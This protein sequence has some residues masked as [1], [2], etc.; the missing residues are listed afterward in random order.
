MSEENNLIFSRCPGCGDELEVVEGPTDRYGGSSAAC[1]KRFTEILVREYSSPA[2]FKVH[3]LTVDAYMA[4]HPSQSSPAAIQSVWVHLVAIY[5]AL[6]QQKPLPFIQKVMKKLARPDIKFV[7]LV[8]PPGPAA[9]TVG[10][11]WEAASAEEHQQR[12]RLWAGAVWESWG[13]RQ[14]RIRDLA[15]YTIAKMP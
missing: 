14:E 6:E 10:H 2:H 13:D 1:W 7:A 9:L 5:L 8:P 11:V 15:Q 4:Q 3:Q 12:V